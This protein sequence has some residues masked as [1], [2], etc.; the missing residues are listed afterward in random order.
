[1]TFPRIVYAMADRQQLPFSKYL[2][3]LNRKSHEPMIATTAII[4]YASIMILFFNPDRLSD[5][6]IFTVYCFYVATFVGVFLLRHRHP[7]T[8]RPFSTPGFPITP[9]IAI[10]GALFVIISEI[11]SDFT[12]VVLSL[13]IVAAG[14][15]VYYY[16]QHHRT[17]D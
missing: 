2:S 9:L 6:C 8:V 16:K 15:P 3:Y 14:I 4:A 13:V 12:G 7:T 1:M 5:L 11:G 10:L 17:T